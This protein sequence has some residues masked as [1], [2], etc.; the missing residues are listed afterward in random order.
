MDNTTMTINAV[1]CVTSV[2]PRIAGPV[3]LA[4]AFVM[5]QGTTLPVAAL[6]GD[7]LVGFGAPVK[8]QVSLQ[9]LAIAPTYKTPDVVRSRS[10]R[11][12]V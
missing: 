6:A 10:G 7:R 3:R 2:R 8:G 12:P 4:A 11:P 9:V 5:D 1:S